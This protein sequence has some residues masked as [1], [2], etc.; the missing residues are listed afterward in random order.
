M[1]TAREKLRGASL[2]KLA[3]KSYHLKVVRMYSH[4]LNN[5]LTGI[6]GY[7]QLLLASIEVDPDINDSL[8][9]IEASASRASTAIK[10]MSWLWKSRSRGESLMSLGS[11]VEGVAAPVKYYAGRKS[12]DLTYEFKFDDFP[13]EMKEEDLEDCLYLLILGLID[14]LEEGA[15]LN[16]E[17]GMEENGL[18]LACTVNRPAMIF[19]TLIDWRLNEDNDNDNALLQDNLFLWAF[20][21]LLAE[22]GGTARAGDEEG[23]ALQVLVPLDSQVR[24]N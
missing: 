6:L 23:T 15:S 18:S 2:L 7:S 4:E 1:A 10:H 11:L 9:E 19:K 20:M 14:Y 22:A 5:Y 16:I 17:I 8:K 13:L 21:N 24:L 12:I 3:R